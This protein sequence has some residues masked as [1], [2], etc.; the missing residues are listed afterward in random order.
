MKS[1]AVHGT[2][3]DQTQADAYACEGCSD[4]QY[5]GKPFYRQAWTLMSPDACKTLYDNYFDLLTTDG[6][7]RS[8][9]YV[10]N[11]F[12]VSK[13]P[14]DYDD[15]SAWYTD[16]NKG[17]KPSTHESDPAPKGDI[18][19]QEP[20]LAI[21]RRLML[22]DTDPTSPLQPTQLSALQKAGVGDDMLGWDAL[23]DWQKEA[24]R[25]FA[26]E[27]TN[28]GYGPYVKSFADVFPI[29]ACNASSY[30]FT[31]WYS[32][33]QTATYNTPFYNN[34]QNKPV[35]VPN[36]YPDG[37]VCPPP[38]KETD[39]QFDRPHAGQMCDSGFCAADSGECEGG[40]SVYEMTYGKARNDG[41]T[42]G[43]SNDLG[44]IAL[45]QDNGALFHFDKADETKVTLAS[46]SDDHRHYI[47]EGHSKETLKI[48]DFTANILDLSMLLTVV[49]GAD[50]DA[51]KATLKQEFLIL[52]IQPP[53]MP[54]LPKASCGAAEWK[55]GEY[56]APKCEL[57]RQKIGVG[58]EKASKAGHGE[59]EHGSS[60][61][62]GKA[63]SGANGSPAT[64][65]I[66]GGADENIVDAGE[67]TLAEFDIPLPL[68]EC[69]EELEGFKLVTGRACFAKETLVGPV[70][71]K[72]EAELAPEAKIEFGAELDSETLE[73]AMV[74]KPGIG[75]ALEVKGGVGGNIGPLEIFAGIKAAITII[76]IALPVKF[77]IAFEAATKEA[78]GT[79]TE[80]TDLWLVKKVIETDLDLT[81]LQIALS[82][83]FDVGIGPFKFSIEYEFFGFEGIKFTWK[84]SEAEVYEYKVDF[85]WNP[86][87]T[88]HPTAAN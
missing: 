84:L 53:S 83:F 21:L 4:V 75:L 46:G 37:T 62:S 15:W 65:T 72:V 59:G 16:G 51:D 54:S 38:G 58:V 11:Q 18:L 13:W 85:Q 27:T 40:F 29:G 14:L 3:W 35:C 52:G 26:K 60:G 87:A 78:S 12:Y 61:G 50:D 1:R 64:A 47:L 74:V 24:Y 30:T 2:R 33:G 69:P 44:A 42:G 25:R 41:K 31:R 6:K 8:G 48:F 32:D 43:G 66:G 19:E 82:L 10:G 77:G 68:Q 22:K 39:P 45:V 86:L 23:T 20:S 56:T 36:K 5:S 79:S 34:E 28:I 57:T 55:D 17:S 76:E 71:F 80:V 81:F 67:V 73:P 63:K 88:S 70:P 9:I 49:P 7:G